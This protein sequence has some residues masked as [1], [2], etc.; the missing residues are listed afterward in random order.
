MR[1]LFTPEMA[2]EWELVIDPVAILKRC[3]PD[4]RLEITNPNRDKDDII[5]EQVDLQKEHVIRVE[6]NAIA[7]GDVGDVV[8]HSE[9]KRRKAHQ[10]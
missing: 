8:N 4:D 3:R 10:G 7:F 9:E 1:E 6:G 2:T 5:V